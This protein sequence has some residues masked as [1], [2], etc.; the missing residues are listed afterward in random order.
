M[1]MVLFKE[2]T[3]SPKRLRSY[4]LLSLGLMLAAILGMRTF[5]SAQAQ[6][7]E[8]PPGF[9]WQRM[10]GVGCVQSDC[11]SIPNAKLSYTTACICL[12][13]YKACYEPVDSTGVACGPNCPVSKLVACVQPDAACPGE[14]II[15]SQDQAEP[16]TLIP[17]EEPDEQPGEEAT[18]SII[19]EPQTPSETDLYRDL[20]AFLAG[21]GITSPSLEEIAA[22]GAA[23]SAL[24]ATWVLINL[25]SGIP[26]KSSLQAIDAWRRGKP[27][28][29]P[30]V[31]PT[32]SPSEIKSEEKSTPTT[33]K[34]P[35]KPAES[36]SKV[37]EP[38]SPPEPEMVEKAEPPA[39]PK[40]T[41]TGESS[42][43]RVLRTVQ[44]TQDLD[45]AL[46]NTRKQFEAFEEKIPE[47]IR[48]S[49]E[50]KILVEPKLEK[51]KI[52]SNRG[53]LIKGAPGL[54]ALN[55]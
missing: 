50:W 10:S 46:K 32:T 16:S 55:N 29:E 52:S 4:C 6:E 18:G 5:R 21:E 12:D 9:E 23:I 36:F 39:P 28:L 1:L 22:G 38:S 7:P 54:T 44:D 41:P 19:V 48:K 40:P 45:D 26:A 24:L 17:V 37:P 27:P 49:D 2:L 31:Q 34:P 35:D 3:T 14:V 11:L 42:E 13:G 8:C 25:L 33:E 47:S 53:S 15:P 20:E 30:P 43:A 51:I